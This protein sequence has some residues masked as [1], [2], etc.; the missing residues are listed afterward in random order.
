L[1][2]IATHDGAMNLPGAIS[3]NSPGFAGIRVK[4]VVEFSTNTDAGGLKGEHLCEL[5]RD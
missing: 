2:L 5:D 3:G 1:F 4:K